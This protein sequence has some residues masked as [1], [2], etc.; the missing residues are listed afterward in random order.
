MKK[1]FASYLLIFSLIT[2][3][4]C[5]SKDDPTPSKTPEQIA[6]EKLTGEGS[7]TWIVTGGAVT[8]NGTDETPDWTDFEI[9]FSSNG[10]TKAY[11]TSNA[12]NLYDGSGNWSFSGN[13]FDKITLTGSQP[14]AGEEISFS[15]AG[16]NLVLEFTVP[17]PTNGRVKAL[18]GSYKFELKAK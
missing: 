11:T 12:N 16:S 15:G 4:S 3:F 2:L 5:G 10:S 9:T 17:T 8:H 6:T 1:L 18:A 14:A 7:Q 13:N